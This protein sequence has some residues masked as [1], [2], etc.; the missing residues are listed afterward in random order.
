MMI[1]KNISE[2]KNTNKKY[3][4]IYMTK[5][6]ATNDPSD[7][8]INIVNLILLIICIIMY[9]ISL[10]LILIYIYKTGDKSIS[11]HALSLSV[12]YIPQIIY[13]YYY[14]YQHD[15][16]SSWW[17]NKWGV[18]IVFTIINVFVVILVLSIIGGV[19]AGNGISYATKDDIA[20]EQV[21]MK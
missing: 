20:T 3:Y 7:A 17:K 14:L 16:P 5:D 4:N 12:I 11:Y 10:I 2:K 19:I 9:V 21:D 13:Y 8:S 18:D 1:L 6:D 15:I